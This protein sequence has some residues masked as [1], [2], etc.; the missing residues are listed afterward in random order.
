M[1]F[2][3]IFSVSID[4]FKSKL[5]LLKSNQL[6]DLGGFQINGIE[7]FANFA[8]KWIYFLIGLYYVSFGITLYF[9]SHLYIALDKKGHIH[10]L[11]AYI[12]VIFCTLTT[13]IGGL[14]FFL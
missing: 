1:V 5:D 7:D 14:L 12:F 13:F 9:L 2:L 4:G 10:R 3:P 11:I 6:Q 8:L